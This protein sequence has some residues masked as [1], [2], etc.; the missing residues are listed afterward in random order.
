VLECLFRHGRHDDIILESRLM[1]SSETP[2]G[3]VAAAP[4]TPATRPP[5]IWKFWGTLL[6]G[7]FIFAAMLVGQLAVM[8]WFVLR[9]AN[10]FDFA[11]AMATAAQV[12]GGGLTISLSVIMG[13]PAV[14][15]ALWLP[16]RLSRTSVTDYLAL[17]WTSWSNLAIG[18]VTMV[19]LVMG[20]DMVS[21][22][23]GREVTP[24]FMGDVLR[25][26]STDGALWL[27]VLAFCVA[28]PITEEFFARGF[29]Y[30]G[31][32]ETF[33]RPAGAIVL[34]SLLWTGLHLQYDWFFLSEVF[35]IGLLLGYLR[36]RSHSIW[37]TVVLHGLNN[38]AAVAQTMVLT[39]VG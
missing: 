11:A 29:L 3:I 5:R 36:Y 18:L 33:L 21:R 4:V 39:G 9:Q 31:W 1:H 15:A 38:L 2:A 34:S 17:R 23:M 13:L 19:V 24:G 32:S 20:W 35:S 8:G 12:L 14:L 7:L 10:P 28:A 30:R 16:I 26:A 6:W 27:L 37:L 22:L 25:S